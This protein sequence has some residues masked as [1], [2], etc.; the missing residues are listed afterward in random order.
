MSEDVRSLKRITLYEK[1]KKME[2]KKN[3]L[4][5]NRSFS[6]RKTKSVFSSARTDEIGCLDRWKELETEEDL[7]VANCRRRT[8]LFGPDTGP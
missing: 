4:L 5:S 7:L 3:L 2:E 8:R 1:N 6:Q